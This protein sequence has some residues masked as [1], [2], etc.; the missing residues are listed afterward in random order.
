MVTGNTNGNETTGKTTWSANRDF[1]GLAI[2]ADNNA[3]YAHGKRN[4]ML[5]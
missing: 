3:T 4:G 5:D 2:D 1:L